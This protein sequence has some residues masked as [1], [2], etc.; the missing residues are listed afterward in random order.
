MPRIARRINNLLLIL[1]FNFCALLDHSGKLDEA[2][3]VMRSTLAV[4]RRTV[5]DDH[6]Q[7]IVAINN[8]ASLLR[9]KGK[10]EEGIDLSR[11]ALERVRRVLGAEHPNTIL[12]MN[13]LAH[14]LAATGNYAEAEPLFG[15]V[16][17]R[18]PESQIDPR[19]VA[20]IMSRW[21]PALVELGR[22][23]AAEA[24]LLEAH[25]RLTTTDQTQT[26]AMATVLE[27]LARVCERS[28]RPK[29]AAQWRERRAALQQPA[30]QPSGTRPAP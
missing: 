11:E 7:T 3:T 27:A 1:L 17:R 22:Y 18:A 12:S 30:S 23:D 14:A 28:N 9:K 24:P 16:Y 6:P 19:T 4:S 26:P 10:F 5:G 21:G 29:E 13:N 25:R 20:T 15:E 8:L 2:E